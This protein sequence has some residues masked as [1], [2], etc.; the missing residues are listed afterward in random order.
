MVLKNSPSTSQ[1][2]DLSV[3][4]LFDVSSGTGRLKRTEELLICVALLEYSRPDD[5]GS[6]S[7]CRQPPSGEVEDWNG[8]ARCAARSAIRR[9]H[10]AQKPATGQCSPLTS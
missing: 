1:L 8:G 7:R 3:S 6:S 4:H 2:F 10:H 9:Q 5:R